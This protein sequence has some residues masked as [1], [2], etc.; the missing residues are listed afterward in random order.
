[1]KKWID[2]EVLDEV[3]RAKILQFFVI[4]FTALTSFIVSAHEKSTVTFSF[5]AEVVLFLLLFRFYLKA[6]EN[7]NYAYWGTSFLLFLFNLRVILYYTFFDYQAVILY[8]SF[9]AVIFMSINIYVMSS[10]LFFPRVQWWEYDF[11]YR[12][13][14]KAAAKVD[15]DVFNARLT[16]L[17]RGSG[18]IEIFEYLDIGTEVDLRI[19]FEGKNYELTTN[20]VTR[21]QAIPGR[22]Y[23]YGVKALFENEDQKDQYRELK[24]LWSERIKV[25]LRN[26]FQEIKNEKL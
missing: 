12:G 17:R 15:T 4:I 21:L 10:P 7:R 25:K 3:K 14:L 11:R 9:L 6:Q 20:V 19:N 1:M 5:A 23:R 24:R 2:L 8:F 18:C 13:D 22:A 26:K 16:D